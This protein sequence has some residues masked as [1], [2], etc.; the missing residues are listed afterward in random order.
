MKVNDFES[1][2]KVSYSSDNGSS[3]N[4]EICAVIVKQG[5]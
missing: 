3:T 2:I 4:L 1:P 5:V